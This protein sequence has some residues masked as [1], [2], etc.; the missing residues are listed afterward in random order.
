MRHALL[1]LL[2]VAGLVGQC[3]A[4]EAETIDGRT[5]EDWV[6]QLRGED[7]QGRAQAAD[8]LRR[9]QSLDGKL[10]GPVSDALA[11][12]DPGVRALVA[13]ALFR[14]GPNSKDAID[15]MLRAAKDPSPEVRSWICK[16][17]GRSGAD[18]ARCGP[19][20]VEALQDPEP[21]VAQS[22]CYGL[23]GVGASY[24]K[25]ITALVAVSK[26]PRSP[27]RSSAVGALG[28]MGERGTIGD[29]GAEVAKELSSLLP[30]TD[31]RLR[32]AIVVALGRLGESALESA[33]SLKEAIKDEAPDVRH[34]ATLA[35]MDVGAGGPDLLPMLLVV[36]RES[37]VELSRIRAIEDI[38]KLGTS[39]P[40]V[41]QALSEAGRA[42]SPQIRE[43]ATRALDR[44]RDR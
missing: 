18:P 28:V 12:V 24:S 29:R 40:E 20:L 15:G 10:A 14:M 43:A 36:V 25:A 38:A 32:L 8:A 26:D 30:A 2:A 22:A 16:A 19:V 21:V 35:L 41:E 13:M 39:T 17:L 42:D 3:R 23:S 9:F 37:T 11:D 5:A 31:T 4:Q 27:T 33:P 34:Q 1:I 7:V 44:L 6:V